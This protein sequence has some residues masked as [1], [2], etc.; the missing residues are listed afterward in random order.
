MRL[1]TRRNS[2]IV[3][4]VV[5]ATGVAAALPAP[6][7]GASVGAPVIADCNTHLR[8]THSY[9][10]GALQD[11]LTSMPSDIRE[12][13][14][15]PDVIQQAL[16]VAEGKGSGSRPLGSVNGASSGSG[17]PTVLVVVLVVLALGAVTLGAVAIRR[18][19]T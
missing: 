11:A 9:T 6:A 18:R 14:N 3:S 7:V 10:L 16:N 13:T 4:L 12:Y 17:L 15:C 5:L 8:L 19:R 1:S 2:L